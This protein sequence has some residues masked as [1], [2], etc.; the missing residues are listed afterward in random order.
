MSSIL[1]FLKLSSNINRIVLKTVK[2]ASVVWINE[3]LTKN[4]FQINWKESDDWKRGYWNFKQWYYSPT[5][6]IFTSA[7]SIVCCDSQDSGSR[8]EKRF[9]KA[10]QYGLTHEVN[11]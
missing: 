3:I 8:Q 5:S 11:T 10:I 6:I 7:F 2:T 4:S 9:F 1:H